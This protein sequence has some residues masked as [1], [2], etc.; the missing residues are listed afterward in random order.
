MRLGV[1]GVLGCWIAGGLRGCEQVLR[2][3]ERS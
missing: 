2:T 1:A 3:V